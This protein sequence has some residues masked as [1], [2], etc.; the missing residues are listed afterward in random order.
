MVS[1]KTSLKPEF[2]PKFRCT[3][4]FKVSK[5]CKICKI[6]LSFSL[7]FTPIVLRVESFGK[8]LWNLC[9]SIIDLCWDRQ[10]FAG[11]IK[12]HKND[13]VQV[14]WDFL[15]CIWLIKTPTQGNQKKTHWP[16]N[17]VICYQSLGPFLWCRGPYYCTALYTLSGSK[18]T[19]KKLR[20][21]KQDVWADS[22]FGEDLFF[23][24]RPNK[25]PENFCLS[26][27]CNSLDTMVS[28]DFVLLQLLRVYFHF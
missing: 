2:W 28:W 27:K 6:S 16:S 21:H 25:D 15:T 26:Q 4:N 19:G 22:Y 10:S 13:C 20:R 3:T 8:E 11:L 23:I 12:T 7:G 24:S 14:P 9:P 5:Y 18:R 17:A 1:A